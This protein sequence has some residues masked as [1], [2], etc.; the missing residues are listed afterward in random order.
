MAG[1]KVSFLTVILAGTA[2]GLALSAY[3]ASKKS[4]AFR[5][6]VTNYVLSRLQFLSSRML[7]RLTS[8]LNLE[9]PEGEEEVSPDIS[10][11]AAVAAGP[12]QKAPLS[13]EDIRTAFSA[14]AER[15]RQRLAERWASIR[16]K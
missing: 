14:G 7:E 11:E 6:R 13:E 4:P 12:E 10:K 5:R 8:F 2:I 1:R 15:A 3:A 16:H 9:L